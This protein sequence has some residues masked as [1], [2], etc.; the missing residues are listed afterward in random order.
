MSQNTFYVLFV[1]S[2]SADDIYREKTEHTTLEGLARLFDQD[3]LQATY[4][5]AIDRQHLI[6]AINELGTLGAVF[7]DRFI[8]LHLTAHGDHTGIRLTDGGVLTWDEMKQLID[9]IN[10][11][12]GHRLILCLSTCQGFSAWTMAAG[13]DS[14]FLA[15]IAN[16]GAPS[17]QTTAIG[18][19]T[20][21]HQLSIGA[22][23]GPAVDAMRIATGD[24]NWDHITAADA[25]K[26]FQEMLSSIQLPQTSNQPTVEE[27]GN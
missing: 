15:L 11:Q 27:I 6:S 4:R 24:C 25:K 16:K 9:P 12:L 5:T 26:R 8:V 22:F 14:P 19:A 10:R 2:P 3:V 18:F 21:Y 23:V 17:Y 20:L 13:E 7:P 1:E